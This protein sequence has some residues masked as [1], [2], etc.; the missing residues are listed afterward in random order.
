MLAG[1]AYAIAGEDG[2]GGEFG[3]LGDVVIR[4]VGGGELDERGGG[5]GEGKDLFRR[6]DGVVL[7]ERTD[8]NAGSRGEGELR[9]G[10]ASR[11]REVC[12]GREALVA[13]KEDLRTRRGRSE[14]ERMPGAVGDGGGVRHV[15]GEGHRF[16]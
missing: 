16:C 11:R 2:A 14:R 8:L 7:C 13:V 10:A 5:G 9:V 6:E 12:G 3:Q 1:A 4:Q 15:E